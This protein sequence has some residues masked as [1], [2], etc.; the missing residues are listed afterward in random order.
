MKKAKQILAG[1]LAALLL[2]MPFSPLVQ[3]KA[4]AS[5]LASRYNADVT[6]V[7]YASPVE[8][9]S[10]TNYCWAYMADAVLESYLMK[11][12][13]VSNIDFNEIDMVSQLGGGS[14]GYSNL[15]T[16]G[17]FHQALAYWTRGIMYGPR[18]ESDNS[19]TGYYVSETCE[20][21]SYQRD[22]A[23]SKQNYIQNIK[24][25]VVQYG[26]VGVSL[27]FAAESR[28]Y[29]TKEG[30]YYCPQEA[31]QG[32]NH[33][34]TV[35]G[36]DDQFPAQWF[37]NRTTVPQQPR[38]NG[39]F[40]VKNS[41]GS[42]DPCS[43]NGNTGYYWISYENYFQDA[44]AVT[45]VEERVKLYDYLY[46][47]DYR[48]F[49]GYGA[50][51]GFTQTYTLRPG[52]QWLSGFATYV[53]AGTSYRFYLNGQELT[54]F[55]GTM[56]HSGYHTFQLANPLPVSGTLELR[57]ELT[58]S[59][60]AV[61]IACSSN[62]YE[63]DGSNVCMKVFTRSSAQSPSQWQPDGSSNNQG[64][65]PSTSPTEITG[66][67]LTPQDCTVARGATQVF[68][69]RVVGYG[70]PSQRISWQISGSSSPGTKITDNGILYIGSD[71]ASSVIYIYA[72]AYANTSHSASARVE[73]QNPAS[74][75]TGSS[76]GNGASGNPGSSTGSAPGGSTSGS[77]G[78][79]P[80]GSTVP[81][82][83]EIPNINGS[84]DSG[85]E[86]GDAL[87]V[88]TVG[89]GIYSFWDD[90]TA[91]YSKCKSKS[92][93]SISIPAS[94]IMGGRSYDV[95][96]MDDNCIRGSKKATA[97]TIGK[98]ILQIGDNAFYGC[99]KLKKI[100]IRSEDV[101][102][103]GDNAFYGISAKAVIYVPRSCLSEYREMI[104]ESG[105]YGVKVK[106]YD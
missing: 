19:L 81:D 50:G 70:Q 46:E 37:Y 1:C 6:Y 82:G 76:P 3:V 93:A 2:Q 63:A 105:N 5:A 66:V 85:G 61:P 65:Y 13:G 8:D 14:Y 60:D 52:T 90:G 83:L 26:A 67:T 97:V 38:Y 71:E 33:G 84:A 28:A 56:A 72:N 87:R 98:N 21:G 73:I 35:V 77:T 18:L 34:V 64:I 16:G 25:L 44:F 68:T 103:I 78:S 91:Q 47:T 89:K 9:Q 106:A 88:A 49:Y 94:V 48:G 69:A 54:Q 39:A 95:T 96:V 104:R 42:Y 7:A 59:T 11:N 41:W 58:G 57:A 102:Y 10:Q 62:S 55:S 86:A 79:A 27:D 23:Q 20:L 53:K 75:G 24:N 29:T 12:A 17:S 101:E 40:L 15:Y 43:I 31:S 4:D 51:S 80:G 74:S 92:Y 100:K 36:W 45:Q 22:D 99:K 32:V 30:A